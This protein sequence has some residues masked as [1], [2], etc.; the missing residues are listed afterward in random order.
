MANERT[1]KPTP[2]RREDAR[3]KGQIARRPELSAAA[4]FFAALVMLRVTSD[5]LLGRASHLFTSTASHVIAAESLTISSV[6]SMLMEASSDL[7]ALSL[8]VIAAALAAGLAANFAQGGLT[9]TP[10]AF[11]PR[12]ERFNPAAN[13]KRAFGGNSTIEFLKG[14]FKLGGLIA[15]CY[16]VFARAIADAPTLVGAP[17]PHTFIAVGTLAYQLGLRAGGVLLL[18][19]A[20]DYGYGWYKH[21][22]S[23]KMTKQEVKDEFRQ[24][25]G[26]PTVKHL[27]RRMA[28]ALLQRHIAT[29]VPR[30]DV[31]VTNPTHYAVA[32]R[33]DREKHAAPMV[34]AKGADEMAKR[35]REIAKAHDVAII[36][37]PPLARTLYRTVET[38]RAIPPDLFRAVAELL[39]Y[40]YRQRQYAAQ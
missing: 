15:V 28:R 40:V 33:Y 25:E 5:D 4:G 21:E 38:G 30:A 27:R 6:H 9:F 11:K 12:F 26:D 32:L 13:F 31:V 14:I 2:K 7:A 20:A 18:L 24:Q 16:G 17:A 35:I 8:P 19:A 37:N 36:E 29:E 23:L 39:A 1:E 22:K 3:R 10:Q 34:V